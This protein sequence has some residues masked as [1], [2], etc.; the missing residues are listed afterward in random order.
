M[1]LTTAKVT[2]AA[3][4]SSSQVQQ[5]D[6]VEIF[7]RIMAYLPSLM[8]SAIDKVQMSQ[9]EKVIFSYL[10]NIA[11]GNLNLSDP[12][13]W[14]LPDKYSNF[15]VRGS[16]D[17]SFFKELEPGLPTRI[18]STI[19]G[20]LKAPIMINTLIAN[21]PNRE[22]TIPEAVQIIV[23]EMGWK[24]PGINKQGMQVVDILAAKIKRALEQDYQVI[25]LGP[26]EKLHLL[27]SPIR[28]EPPYLG[29]DPKEKDYDK[30][31]NSFKSQFIRMGREILIFH[32]NQF[33]FT[34]VPMLKQALLNDIRSMKLVGQEDVANVTATINIDQILVERAVNKKPLV[35]FL[36]SIYERAYRSVDETDGEKDGKPVKTGKKAVHSMSAVN[37]QGVQVSDGDDILKTKIEM[38]AVFEAGV[39]NPRISRRE[40][41]PHEPMIQVK[42]MK[43]SEQGA[44]R[45]GSF[46]IDVP[47][48]KVA[49]LITHDLRAYLWARMENGLAR[50]E[51]TKLIPEGNQLYVEFQIPSAAAA[52]Q[53]Y[54]VEEVILKNK[55]KEFVLDLPETLLI[56]N[57]QVVPQKF[58]LKTLERATSENTWTQLPVEERTEENSKGADRL[59]QIK[60]IPG[61]V[62]VR[63]GFQKFR[64][65]FKSQAFLHEVYFYFRA[66][67][68]TH[69]PMSRQA[70]KQL[71]DMPFFG[72]LI[73]SKIEGMEYRS[74][75]HFQIMD[76][77]VHLTASQI[78]QVQRGS[79]LIVEF[80]IPMS[81]MPDKGPNTFDT[82]LRYVGKIIAVNQRLERWR[83]SDLRHPT[84]SVEGTNYGASSCSGFFKK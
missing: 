40:V 10:A 75:S 57:P 13:E 63:P 78:K 84:F 7:K 23:H 60:N 80:E 71:I 35:R 64:M 48:D 82:G 22:I 29:M 49:T 56:R 20:D 14:I 54:A 43:W 67:Y 30:S 44:S 62:G 39:P 11:V 31:Q 66:M 12:Q 59:D 83:I 15:V 51:V 32:E 4:N 16:P 50:I 55:E 46:K 28:Y 17:Q 77:V 70:M 69:D 19:A 42:D 73:T 41:L 27:N 76:Q 24:I 47:K 3:P 8:F 1:V 34:Y 72:G 65:V 52:T 36:V 74:A 18:A 5:K 25:E 81:V 6:R 68:L 38:A 9:I 37:G 26:N 21:D 45:T 61:L 79:D 53:S 33:G 2:L 58:E